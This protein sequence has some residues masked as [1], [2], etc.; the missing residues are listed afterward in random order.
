MTVTGLCTPDRAPSTED[1]S[2]GDSRELAVLDSEGDLI[3][4]GERTNGP[5]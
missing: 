5:V 4:F 3:K 1:S 2:H